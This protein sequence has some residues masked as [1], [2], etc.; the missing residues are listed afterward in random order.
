MHLASSY[1][2][3]WVESAEQLN[4]VRAFG[5]EGVCLCRHRTSRD[6]Q[7]LCH[8]TGQRVLYVNPRVRR[9][10]KGRRRAPDS[11]LKHEAIKHFDSEFGDNFRRVKSKK[12]GD[13]AR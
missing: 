6:L 9:E 11:V 7:Y 10:R 5:A 4:A 12:T 1:I 3:G 13:L 8:A 2:T